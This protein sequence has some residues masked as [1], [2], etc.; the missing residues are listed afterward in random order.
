VAAKAHAKRARYA[1]PGRHHWRALAAA[2]AVLLA[3][4][5]A[6]IAYALSG[7]SGAT[8]AHVAGSAPT[9]AKV[10]PLT[11]TVQ[12]VDGSVGLPLDG[13]VTVT[14]GHGRLNSV[15][16][17]SS[18]SASSQSPLAGALD[19]AAESWQST[20]ALAPDTQ[21]TVTVH[22]VN[23]AGQ[24][25][26]QISHFV[27]MAPKA[28]L[29]VTLNPGDNQ[30]V[31]I[32]MPIELRF[33]HSVQNKDAIL[34]RLQVTESMP[35]P[36]GWH[37]FSDRELH[38]R[39]E[40]YWPTG[41]QVS[42]V[43][44]LAGFDAGNGIWG[45]QNHSVHFVIGPAHVSTADVNGHVLTVTTNG[46]VVGAYPLSA[47]RTNLPTMG[48][49]HIAVFKSQV[50][51]MVS[52][53]PGDSYDELVYWDVNI[54]DGGEFV[55]AA[56]WST[57]A[58]GRSNV[59]HGCINLSVPNAVAFYNFSQIGDIVNVVGSPRPP[60]TGDHG[61][62][63]WTTPWAEFI[64]ASAPAPPPAVAPVPVPHGVA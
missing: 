50:V 12:P 33:N 1:A 21:Y 39:P 55:H 19:A 47:G 41:D 57:G 15:Q 26:D 52:T 63:D 29:G 2:A 3:A 35:L 46:Q 28:I 40:Q 4:G 37:W 13:V 38:F 9:A 44:N 5:A 51:R 54:T 49:V 61:T 62:M 45:V 7:A 53:T 64:P 23:D 6:G 32:G 24:P 14:A 34:S 31:G 20:G 17:A 8:S 18:A 36:G 10:P 11:L 22:A 56:P 60:S 30:T 58:Q 27:T 59:S 25:A 43:A 42:L 48:G 16:V